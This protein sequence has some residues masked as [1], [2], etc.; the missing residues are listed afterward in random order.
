DYTYREIDERA[1]RMA[2]HL[3]SLG[4]RPGEHI[5]VHS[6]NRIEWVDALYGSFKARAVP[7]NVN[8]KYLLEEL[9]HVYTDSGAVVAIVAPE[10]ADLARE[11]GGDRLRHVIVMGEDHD[12]AMAAAST[13]RPDIGAS[14]DDHYV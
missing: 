8:Y 1:T 11:A 3:L 4:V 13:E 6:P 2:N 12:A 7:I 9:T 5:A 14:E 10:Y